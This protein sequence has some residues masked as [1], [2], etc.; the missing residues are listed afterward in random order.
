VVA[1]EMVAE[2]MVDEEV[3]AKE[4][5]AEEQ[6]GGVPFPPGLP[7]WDPAVPESGKGIEGRGGR[8]DRRLWAR[9]GKSAHKL[10]FAADMRTSS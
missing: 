3:V 7:G 9:D 8:S 2:E 6:G 1:E 5:V 10:F 4:V